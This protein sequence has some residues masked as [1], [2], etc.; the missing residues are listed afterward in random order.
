MRMSSEIQVPVP[1]TQYYVQ[2][3]PH[4]HYIHTMLLSRGSVVSLKKNL[5]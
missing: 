4:T 2:V 1:G 5:F 3:V